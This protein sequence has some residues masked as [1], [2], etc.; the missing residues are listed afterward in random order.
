MESTMADAMAS[1]ASPS[2][3][4]GAV[5]RGRFVWYDLMTT[6][7][8]AAQEFYTKLVGWTMTP[9]EGQPYSMWTSQDGPIGGVMELPEEARS[10][11]APAHWVPYV[12]VA[13][14][15]E[16]VE[17]AKG[18]GANV[19]VPP[20][21]IPDI[22]RFAVLADPQGATFAVFTASSE[23][24]GT[25]NPTP[26]TFSWHELMT[27]DYEKA[28]DFYH[29]LFGWE[30]TGAMD[31]GDQ[32]GMYQMFGRS[33][34]PAGPSG[35]PAMLG[36]MMNKPAN[37]PM[38]PAWILYVMIDDADEGVEQVKAMGGQIVYG[39]MDVPGGDRVAQAIDPQGAVFGVHSR[40]KG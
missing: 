26:G 34:A 37:V 29:D 20:T 36:G 5:P 39:P 13:N 14:V 25:D 38:P 15:D 24:T 28:F 4:A 32:G 30:K 6:D 35:E 40:K 22:G 27:T 1:A 12:A 31:M 7:P 23:W 9:F 33:G 3:Q 21:D 19:N 18:H 2:T 11:G 17:Q 8:A 16:T 10:H